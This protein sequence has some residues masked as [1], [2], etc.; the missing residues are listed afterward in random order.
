MNTILRDGHFSRPVALKAERS[1]VN[2]PHRIP[3]GAPLAI[4]CS[5]LNYRPRERHHLQSGINYAHRAKRRCAAARASL[6]EA[7][8][9]VTDTPL[10]DAVAVVFAIVGARALVKIFEG[11][12]KAGFME[13]VRPR[14]S[15]RGICHNG[16][17]Y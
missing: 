12:E 17:Y 15:D 3:F 6:S 8:A 5:T 11:L 1:V 13:R 4:R 2:S 9:I 16:H 14:S 7:L 10:R